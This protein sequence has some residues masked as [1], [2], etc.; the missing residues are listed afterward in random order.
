MA[1]IQECNVVVLSIQR[2]HYTSTEGDDDQKCDTKQ[3]HV[4]QKSES[5]RYIMWCQQ[6]PVLGGAVHVGQQTVVDRLRLALGTPHLQT[7]ATVVTMNTLSAAM[8]HKL[9][10]AIR[11]R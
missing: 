11:K 2:Y 9:V 5:R 1:V 8:K 6:A 3:R 10:T 4:Q 7:R